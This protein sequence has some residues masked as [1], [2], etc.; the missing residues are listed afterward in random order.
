MT[1]RHPKGSCG[2]RLSAQLGCNCLTAKSTPTESGVSLNFES[3]PTAGVVPADLGAV[4]MEQ[5]LS[6]HSPD[7]AL[8]QMVASDIET[9]D[10]YNERADHLNKLTPERIAFLTG[11]TEVVYVGDKGYLYSRD[12]EGYR[13]A[14]MEGEAHRVTECCGATGTGTD[15]GTACRH[16]YLECDDGIGTSAEMVYQPAGWVA[17]RTNL[18]N[19]GDAKAREHIAEAL[20]SLESYRNKRLPRNW[21]SLVV[22]ADDV[23]GEMRVCE[24]NGAARGKLLARI[25]H[26]GR[27][28]SWVSQSL[29]TTIAP[30][31]DG[32]FDVSERSLTESVKCELDDTCVLVREHSID[33]TSVRTSTP[34]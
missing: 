28:D 33:C 30:R 5:A 18:D 34:A 29:R 10:E 1:N 4:D 20:T 14:W 7:F 21:G 6:R 25:R 19:E 11:D 8:L 2:G 32:S 12:R 31:P 27:V 16:C 24:D 17:W 22:V 3:T 15:Y 13:V 9:I 23:T 26:D